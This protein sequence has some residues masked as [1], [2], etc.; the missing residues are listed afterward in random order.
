M[1]KDYRDDEPMPAE[2][3]VPLHE[4]VMDLSKT[5]DEAMRRIADL[6]DQVAS[7]N[8]RVIFELGTP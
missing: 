2:D 7:L 6:D 3:R 8:K 5:L 1:A 4:R